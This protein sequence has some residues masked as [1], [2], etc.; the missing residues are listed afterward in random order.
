ML[1][2]QLLFFLLIAEAGVLRRVGNRLFAHASSA[3]ENLRLQHLFALTRLALHVVDGV[4]VFNVS[5]E[6]ENHGD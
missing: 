4:A 1:I 2:A 3:H 6:A 5:V